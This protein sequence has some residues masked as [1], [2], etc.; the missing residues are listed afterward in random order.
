MFTFK[1][2]EVSKKCEISAVNNHTKSINDYKYDV[3]YWFFNL[4]PTLPPTLK[5]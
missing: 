1:V 5:C 3:F 4:I 2:C